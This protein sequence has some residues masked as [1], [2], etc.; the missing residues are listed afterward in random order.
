MIPEFDGDTIEERVHRL[1]RLCERRLQWSLGPPRWRQ[2]ACWHLNAA[3]LQWW[4]H[5]L[6][7]V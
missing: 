2:H 3:A 5:R 7:P 4:A 1:R 6:W